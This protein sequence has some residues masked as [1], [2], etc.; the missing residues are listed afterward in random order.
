MK[1]FF[2]CK[3]SLGI[4]WQKGK[5]T[6]LLVRGKNPLRASKSASCGAHAPYLCESFTHATYSARMKQSIPI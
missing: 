3:I 6:F 4:E 2:L 5:P 1:V